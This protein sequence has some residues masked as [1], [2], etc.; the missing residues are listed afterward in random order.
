[1]PPSSTG[2]A[3]TAFLVPPEI[4]IRH[5]ETRGFIG[6]SLIRLRD[7]SILMAAPWGRP[8]VDFRQLKEPLPMPMIYLSTDQGHTWSEA[9]R[10]AMAWM[11][12]GIPSDG[13]IS[14]LR[15][16]DG[17]IAA[18]FNHNRAHGGGM[19]AVTFSPDE[20]RTWAPARQLVPHDDV[21]Y[22]M[23]DRLIQTGSGRLIVPVSHKIGQWEGD[24]DEN[25]CVLSDDAGA[26]WRLSRGNLKL[27]HTRGL[28]EPAVTELADGR[29][30]LLARTGAGSHH[31]AW[32]HDDGETWTAPQPTTLTAACSPLTLHRLPDG[33]LIVF[34]N[35][36][37]PLADGA[38]FPRNP[39]VY[40]T[41]ADAGAS[42]SAPV[43]I[44]DEA[45]PTDGE[46]RQ[47]IYPGVCFLPEGILLV[48]STQRANLDGSFTQPPGAWQVGGGKRCLFPYPA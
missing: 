39:L 28:A 32:S 15:L 10:F 31:C 2:F 44:D 43:V 18:V 4:F 38:F 48:Y 19:P 29:L 46:T 41:S 21:F 12:D 22:V 30:I 40:A 7:G 34:Y 33:R 26:T 24:L 42:W 11:L 17:R 1:M 13:G 35:H 14:F 3:R 45:S 25:L 8:P 20:G 37:T 47:H 9:G 23:N 5:T 27:A 6:P 16:R 36:A